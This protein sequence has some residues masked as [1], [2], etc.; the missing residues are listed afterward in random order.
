MNDLA[1]PSEPTDTA[2]D[3]SARGRHH[4]DYSIV[5]PVYC[6]EG[7]LVPLFGALTAEV[8]RANADRVGEIVFVDDGSKDG[9]F[10]ELKRIRGESPDNVTIVRLTRNF[11]QPSALL[12]GYAYAKGDCVVTISADGQEPPELINEMLRGY[13][14]EH[15]EIVICARSGRDESLYRSITSRM[16]FSAMRRLTFSNMPRGGFDIWL[17]SRRALEALLRNPDASPSFQWR[18]LWMGYKTK[19][20][21][22]RR[23]A[24]LAGV[25]RYTFAKKLNAVLDG[26]LGHSVAPIRAMWLSGCAFSLVGLAAAVFVVVDALVLGNPATPW[27]PVVA[28]LLMVGG[29]QM[30]M[31]GIVGEY[32]WR[33]LTQARMRDLYLIDEVY[34]A[35]RP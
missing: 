35:E 11:G 29:L 2:R 8:L 4:V 31:L 24:R 30:T 16:Y 10:E 23:R 5:I 1:P 7:C 17:M 32:I 26:I 13:F 15:N 28:A 3:A 34:P 18:L 12:A 14:E 22:Y 20:I 9:S 33:T 27:V 21:T 6:N 19:T 25:S